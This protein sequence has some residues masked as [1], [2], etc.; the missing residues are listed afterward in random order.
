[1]A[2]G[3]MLA[4][5]VAASGWQP[6]RVALRPEP[7]LVGKVWQVWKPEMAFLKVSQYG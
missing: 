1:M 3:Y 2:Q 7:G 4:Y 5:R 6:G